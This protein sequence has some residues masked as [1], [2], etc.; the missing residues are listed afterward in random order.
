MPRE[1]VQKKSF[2]QG[3]EDLKERMKEKRNKRLARAA[4]PSIGRSNLNKSGGSGTTHTILKSV[5]MNNKALALALQAEK[6]K[7]RQ[8]SMVILQLKR[9][10]QAMLA[11]LL[12]LRKRVEEQ[13]AL[14]ADASEADPEDMLGET[15]IHQMS[16]WKPV[17][18]K[19]EENIVGEPSPVCADPE[20]D[21]QFCDRVA[22]LPSTVTVRRRHTDR[23]TRRTSERLR[24]P[25]PITDGDPAGAVK[26]NPVHGDSK[27]QNQM[28]AEPE[29]AD[30]SGTVEVHPSPKPA[31]PRKKPQQCTR[32][33]TQQQARSRPEPASQKPDRGR[34]PERSQSKKPWENPKP[35]AR[36]KSRDRSATRAKASA[37]AP[38]QSNKLNTTLGCNDTFD[39]DC[40]ETIHVMPFKA[41]AE[42]SQ[43]ATP[44]GE[45]SQTE[46]DSA[47]S[48][49]NKNSATSS[50]ESEDSLYVPKK[51]NKRWISPQK[52]TGIPTRRGRS[53]QVIREKGNVS[54]I[55]KIPIYMDEESGS[56]GAE[57]GEDKDP[58]HFSPDSTHNSARL[59]QE[60]PQ[61]HG[62]QVAG[63]LL[64]VSPLVEA[65]M[66]MDGVLSG[67]GE[68]PCEDILSSQT[69]QKVKTGRKRGVGGRKGGQGFSLC[70]VTNMSPTAYLDFPCGG[71]RLSARCST[72][73]SDHKR[74]RTTLNYKEPSLNG[75][76]RRGDKFTDLQFLCSPIFKQ[77]SS[78][79]AVQKS[80]SRSSQ[81]SFQKYN[82]SLVGCG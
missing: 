79:N 82:E 30:L 15:Q 48:E 69:P 8:A 12:L 78:R 41:K 60:N 54:Q 67:L 16:P 36:S 68:N 29:A 10:Q 57:S 44:I 76:L 47:R 34:K 22:A 6:L 32:K 3:L 24:E 58:R 28:L 31:P 49:Q 42:D 39:F 65:E 43:P 55:Q 71:E 35:R 80:N 11:Q 9:D 59:D 20:K 61:R 14:A 2:Q 7:V 75:K 4:A 81:R 40:E 53:S 18:H 51:T 72:P 27:S 74:R 64:P 46:E 25:T 26:P 62:G 52:S 19:S 1:P 56:K 70:D 38:K 50:S 21:Q 5:Q 45:E 23:T 77:K 66:R 73:V 17:V 33:Q 63:D 37:P 13:Q